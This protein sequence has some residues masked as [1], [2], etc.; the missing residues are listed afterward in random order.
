MKLLEQSS[1]LF[2]CILHGMLKVNSG[3][4]VALLK[5]FIQKKIYE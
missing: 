2:V 4:R 1:I 5:I 3:K